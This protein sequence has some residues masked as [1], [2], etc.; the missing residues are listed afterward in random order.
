MLQQITNKQIYDIAK[1]YTFC[2][3]L[4][5][6]TVGLVSNLSIIVVLSNLQNFRGNQCAFYLIVESV[7]NIGLILTAAPSGI[8]SYKLNQDLT[9]ISLI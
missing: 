6:V 5:N 9:Y 1:T 8:I 3:D 2:S 7:F 4:F